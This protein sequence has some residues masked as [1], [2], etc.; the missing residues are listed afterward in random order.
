VVLLYRRVRYGY[1]FRKI[2][3]KKGKFAIVDADDYE[4][5]SRYKWH[6]SSENSTYYAR[7]SFYI[8]KTKRTGAI[9]MH[10][11]MLRVPAGF[12]VDHINRNTLDNRKANLRCATAS[13]NSM[14]RSPYKKGSSKY[15][16]V[17]F[18]RRL[19]K[20]MVFIGRNRENIYLGCFDDEI[21]AAKAYDAAA[22]K[23]HGEFA[24][25]NFPAG[26]ISTIRNMCRL[27]RSGGS[28]A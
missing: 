25:L 27:R 11:D 14:N 21:A 1:S 12:C 23:Y 15:R 18:N 28:P 22:R 17:S 13:E 16:G 9:G 8:K 24:V 6:L 5:L 19:G 7:R 26:L 2:P 3:L 10:Q 20:F 4:R